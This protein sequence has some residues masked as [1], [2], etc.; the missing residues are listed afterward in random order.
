M[1]MVRPPIGAETMTNNVK[2]R[3][4]DSELDDLTELSSGGN[5]SETLRRLIR[6]EKR[7]NARRGR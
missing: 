1:R 7:R 2:F 4:T 5:V 3:L 6:E